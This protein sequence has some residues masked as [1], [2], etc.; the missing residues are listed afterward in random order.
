MELF[1]KLAFFLFMKDRRLLPCWTLN[2]STLRWRK[3]PFQT[4]KGNMSRDMTK[5]TKWLCAQRRLWSVIIWFCHDM[6]NTCFQA[7]FSLISKALPWRGMLCFQSRSTLFAFPS[8]LLNS[9]ILDFSSLNFLCV[10][11]F[12]IFWYFIDASQDSFPYR[13]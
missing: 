8:P 10:Q 13:K 7:I 4:K 5:S 12:R 11:I 6:A 1:S 3:A 9:K 2:N